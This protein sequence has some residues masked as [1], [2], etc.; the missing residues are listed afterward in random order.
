MAT[1]GT[2]GGPVRS[3][4]IL[5]SIPAPDGS[6]PAATAQPSLFA[7]V[8]VTGDLRS[9]TELAGVAAHLNGLVAGM[10]TIAG[11]GR[12]EVDADSGWL[13]LVRPLPLQGLDF[14]GMTRALHLLEM[15]AAGWQSMRLERIERILRSFDPAPE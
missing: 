2:R 13:L 3:D 12:F 7:R 9:S 10:P 11:G 5:P 6:R 1:Q 14:G 8:W 15:T 4:F